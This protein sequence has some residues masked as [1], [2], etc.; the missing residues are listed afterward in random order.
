MVYIKSSSACEYFDYDNDKEKG[1]EKH[2]FIY[3]NGKIWCEIVANGKIFSKT[4]GSFTPNFTGKL[5][6]EN[7]GLYYFN[8]RWYD[9]NL[10]RFIT[11][12]TARDGRNWFVYCENNPLINVDLTR[13][14]DIPHAINIAYMIVQEYMN[15]S[16]KTFAVASSCSKNNPESNDLVD[17]L[18]NQKKQL[19][20]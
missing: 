1:S 19:F 11:E 14:F 2:Y 7:T 9:A 5:H 20:Y 16:A 13:K 10:G 18:C 4:S 12:D 3:A 6:D 17:F 15:N 8:A